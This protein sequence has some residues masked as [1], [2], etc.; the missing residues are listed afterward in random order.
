MPAP[1][2]QPAGTLKEIVGATDLHTKIGSVQ[3][4][5]F[6][7]SRALV[8]VVASSLTITMFIADFVNIFLSRWL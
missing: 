3:S 2:L 7:S 8:Y 6:V 5:V 4:H 1:L